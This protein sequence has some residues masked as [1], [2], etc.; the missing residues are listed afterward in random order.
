MELK[1]I[2]VEHPDGTTVQQ[3]S[4]VVIKKCRYLEQSGCVG[5]CVNIC[6]V[7]SL[8]LPLLRCLVAAACAL[9][10][11]L[12]SRLALA[13]QEAAYP[14]RLGTY[15]ALLGKKQQAL[16]VLQVPTQDFFTNDFGMPLYMEPN[17]EDLSCRMNFGQ[18][19]PPLEEDP[20]HTQPCFSQCTLPAFNP[21]LRLFWAVWGRALVCACYETLHPPSVYIFLDAGC[22]LQIPRFGVGDTCTS[23]Q[24]C[25]LCLGES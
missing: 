1:E 23:V 20:A 4:Q 16:C 14:G 8:P 17:F 13:S 9:Q 12:C 21:S 2:E 10:F 22:N 6:K 24:A 3:R 18:K 7:G 5:L 11:S 25:S 15:V 19:P